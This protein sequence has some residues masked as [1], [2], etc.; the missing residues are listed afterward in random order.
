MPFP[1]V[2]KIGRELKSP[3]SFPTTAQSWLDT[4]SSIEKVVEVCVAPNYRQVGTSFS[5]SSP[6]K[7]PEV[8][9]H[10]QSENVSGTA[11]PATCGCFSL[12][13]P[14]RALVHIRAE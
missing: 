13:L 1:Y 2:I 11:I 6:P 8:F 10:R 7:K 9:R 3:S 4:Q 5:I 14:R 12:H